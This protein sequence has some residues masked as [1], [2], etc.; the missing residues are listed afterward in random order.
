MTLAMSST[1][2]DIIPKILAACLPSN[3]KIWA[4][5]LRASGRVKPYSDLDLLI[6]LGRR[7]T[8]SE[9]A[10]LS[11]AFSDSDLPWKVDFIDRHGTEDC[12]LRRIEPDCILLS[13]G[14]VDTG[15]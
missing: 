1:H 11:E 5:G 8:L 12:F 9:S 10:D 2:L 3:A 4:F 7:L 13:H 15:A 6:D 14:A